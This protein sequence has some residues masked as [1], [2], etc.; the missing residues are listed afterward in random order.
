[1]PSV[2]NRVLRSAF[3]GTRAPSASGLRAA[4]RRVTWAHPL[5]VVINPPAVDLELITPKSCL[6]KSI[7]GTSSVPSDARG[8]TRGTPH[9]S[10][11]G[12]CETS[13]NAASATSAT[14]GASDETGT[15]GFHLSAAA[16]APA[17]FSPSD[18]MY[19][20]GTILGARIRFLLDS[21]AGK[22]FISS[23]LLDRLGRKAFKK[24]SSDKV[25]LP[26]GSYMP[27]DSILP[28]VRI[29][30]S[31]F[32]DAVTFHV[33]PLATFDVILG[34]PWLTQHNPSVDWVKHRVTV[35]RNKHKYV[36]L[37]PPA[38]SAR[39]HPLLLSAMQ[40][41]KA[42]R[43]GAE[44]YLCHIKTISDPSATPSDASVPS[45][46]NTSGAPSPSDAPSV[47]S[48]SASEPKPLVDVSALLAEFSDIF[49]DDLTDMPPHRAVDHVIETIPGA[50]PPT[51]P[52]IRLSPPELDLLRDTIN[53][54][55]DK[56]FIRPSTSP[57][58]APVL[59]VKKK[60]QSMRL[61]TDFRALNAI[62]VKNTNPLP[63]VDMIFDQL[64][65]TKVVSRLD[66][67][68]GYWQVRVAEDSIHKTAFKTRYG[69]YE[70]TVL[71]FGLCN[72]PATF[73]R[74]MNDIFRPF[75]DQFV[76][77]F[78]DD[79]LVY[80]DSVE[81]HLQHLRAVFEKLREHKLYAK[82]SKCSFAM[83]RTEFL[84]HV[85]SEEG[86][87][88]DPAKVKAV[89]EWPEPKAVSS[90]RSFLG[91][92][93]YYR[94]FVNKF[95]SIAD[96][97]YALLPKHAKWDWSPA[98]QA[99]F[100]ALKHALATA[101]V[102]APP[103]FTK[104]FIVRTDA[105]GVG[106]GAVLVQGTGD[107]ERVIAYL[108]RRLKPAEAR[109]P[110]H[111]IE[112]LSVVYALRVWRHYLLGSPFKVQIQTDNTPTKHVMTKSDLNARQAR[113]SGF[114]AEYDFSIEYIPGPTNVVA[115]ALS[116]RPDYMLNALA[117]SSVSVLP[118]PRD[119]AL[120]SSVRDAASGDL[121]YTSIMDE[122]KSSKRSDFC[123][124]HGVLYHV[125]SSRLYI[126]DGKLRRTLL[127]EAHDATTSGHL[128]RH[129][130]LA[131]LQSHFYWPNMDRT[132]RDYVRTC[133]A[134][135]HNKPSSQ[136]P[137][138][139]LQPLPIPERTWKDVSIDL[140][141]ALPVTASGHDAI[142]VVV[143]R[144]SKM[145]HC[146]P[147]VTAI[148]AP[149]LARLYFDN[150][151][152]FHGLPSSV[153][154]DRDPRFISD[155]WSSLF[156]H[157]KTKLNMSTANHPQ[158]DGQTERANRTLEDMLRAYVSPF[159]NDWDLHLTAAE[160]AY[161]SSVQ[162]STG[163]TPFALN[164]GYTPDD[165]L[166][167]LSATAKLPS[168]PRL[169]G[170]GFLQQLQRDL[171]SAKAALVKAQARQAAAY[172]K[173]HRPGSFVVGDKV[174][175]SSKH[176]SNIPGA[177]ESS[178]RKLGPKAYG[179]FTITKVISP[180]VYRLQLPANI[181]IF[182]V[183]HISKLRPWHDGTS[184][185]PE[186]PVTHP[187]APDFIDGEEHFHVAAFLKARYSNTPRAQY[188]VEFT[189]YDAT[190]NEWILVSQ[191]KEDLSADY[192]A[193]LEATFLSKQ[194]APKAKPARRSARS[195]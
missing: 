181:K 94:R 87:S 83:P 121:L 112:L 38:T 48:A 60:D 117:T 93:N 76:Q 183:L 57:Y 155:F 165:P 143:D 4:A 98:Q 191:L 18:L 58:G 126:P 179:P 89:V 100:E 31:G 69:L 132:I 46:H 91:L 125:P 45:V 99:S 84:G 118:S 37:P 25:L 62:T 81:S 185:F 157:T 44:V 138:G 178:V 173:H 151:F 78:I 164:Y 43:Q 131:R 82:L 141:T 192:F 109:Y 74:M 188:L 166:S 152:K 187:P 65:G 56:G 189:G 146:I 161:N 63:H 150:I 101:P 21:A 28:S 86:I 123:I 66:L 11:Q 51:R 171:I 12:V 3:K 172:N 190:F 52:V 41:K 114:L 106:L 72:A 9:S 22:N 127:H 167:L 54:L 104:P 73:T 174:L 17:D 128:G 10:V 107:S 42:V 186:R 110:T 162:A 195:R 5:S 23:H 159:H 8:V 130:M 27:S 85:I 16:F 49:P 59:F 50:T 15:L 96:P 144:L 102:V 154:S 116:R 140:I 67:R 103:D 115:D 47:P 113:W 68:S 124:S 24:A 80:S 79:I 2:C 40:F 61:V 32:A 122:V 147:T 90:L 145:I 70:Y 184:Q 26:D 39:S 169:T 136:P 55:L 170:A 108:S 129:K 163:H 35:V 95:A 97:L 88:C 194:S 7:K 14:S 119:K 53:D 64:H 193:S 158:T 148:K 177:T 29:K 134:C 149:E 33:L 1:M 168:V 133:P 30:L 19:L 175:L 135:Q 75:L 139:L 92:A 156:K 105:S 176:F 13:Q 180:V 20:D 182:P 142:V 36:L 137:F 77:V 6:Q 34:K 71:P 153:V 120:L 111:D 160:F